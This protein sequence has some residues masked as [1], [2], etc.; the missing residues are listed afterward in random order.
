MDVLVTV[1]GGSHSVVH[2][3][4]F[5]LSACR[6][7]LQ[8]GLAFQSSRFPGSV[9]NCRCA[10]DPG[11]AWCGHAWNA[12]LSKLAKFEPGPVHARSDPGNVPVV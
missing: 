7:V 3:F 2:S 9:R 10:Y 12:V 8:N 11:P 5:E 1:I 4:Y 6:I